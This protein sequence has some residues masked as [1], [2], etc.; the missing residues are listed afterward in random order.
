MKKHLLHLANHHTRK[1]IIKGSKLLLFGTRED[2]VEMDEQSVLAVG[3]PRYTPVLPVRNDGDRKV[4][5][6][7]ISYLTSQKILSLVLS[8]PVLLKKF[9]N[10]IENHSSIETK[11]MLDYWITHS[12][13]WGYLTSTK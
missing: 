11:T 4:D 12:C 9:Q 2:D 6:K 8:N 13:S 7:I 5:V 1:Q 3:V 10:S